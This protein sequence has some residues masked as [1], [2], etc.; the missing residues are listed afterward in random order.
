MMMMEAEGFNLYIVHDREGTMIVLSTPTKT[1][2]IPWD[3]QL[4][5]F[6]TREY[7]RNVYLII[8][9]P[10][11][12]NNRCNGQ[13][14]LFPSERRRVSIRWSPYTSVG[15]FQAL[16]SS[17]ACLTPRFSLLS[18]LKYVLFARQHIAFFAFKLNIH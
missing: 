17:H 10:Q 6:L 7:C 4:N 3:R 8:H 15:L 2:R 13:R 11:T 12:T 1:G 5:H 18:F 14:P 16:V 9:S